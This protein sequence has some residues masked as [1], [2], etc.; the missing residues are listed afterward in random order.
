MGS[1]RAELGMHKD[2]PRRLKYAAAYIELNL[3]N[4][5]SDELEAISF[6]D[7]LETPVLCVRLELHTAAKH[8]DVVAGVGRALA[9]TD[10]AMARAWLCWADAL[11][12]M[13][14]IEEAKE[15][16]K[17]AEAIHG[18]TSALLHFNLG[19]FDCLLGNFAAARE[20]LNIACKM[21]AKLKEAALDAPD[22]RGIWDDV[23]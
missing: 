18:G 16:L 20:R 8:W 15:V 9:E 1:V 2:T 21:D 14:R 11:R 4:E 19:R 10:P 22:L 12:E 7:R 6:D 17:T 3:L 13:E 5:A 23:Q